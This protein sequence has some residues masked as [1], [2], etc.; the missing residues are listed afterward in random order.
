MTE[1]TA[2]VALTVLALYREPDAL[3]SESIAA[4]GSAG[5]HVTRASSDRDFLHRLL[6]VRYQIIVLD[7]DAVDM[8][9]ATLVRQVL[10]IQGDHST[11]VT[12][13][14]ERPWLETNVLLALEA[15]EVL[16]RPF[17]SSQLVAVAFQL[18]QRLR[19]RTPSPPEDYRTY[20]THLCQLLQIMSDTMAADTYPDALRAL[21]VNLRQIFQHR[22]VGI[23]HATP[24]D[25]IIYV[26]TPETAADTPLGRRLAVALLKRYE[27]LCGLQVN[28]ATLQERI[29]ADA[30]A[31]AAGS[32]PVTET[33]L[34]LPFLGGGEVRGVLGLSNLT[35]SDYRDGNLPFVYLLASRLYPVLT[36]L[37]QLKNLAFRDG[38]TGLHN[39]AH[40]EEAVTKALQHSRRSGRGFCVVLL[41][42]DHLKR[43][44]DQL[45][46]RAGDL[47][48]RDFAHLL[49]SVSR[50]TDTVG[51]LGGDEFLV[52]LPDT[53][54]PGLQAFLLR[55]FALITTHRTLWAGQP[56]PISASAG[57]TLVEAGEALVLTASDVIGRSDAAMY[58]A[59]RGGKSC[60]AIW[61]PESASGG[62]AVGLS[63]PLPPMPG[64]N[65]GRP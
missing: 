31:T 55:L 14:H 62:G 9:V 39:R 38:L 35:E 22:A 12:T 61:S 37:N 48:L 41:D 1:P 42:L 47:L 2:P 18:V 4:L 15:P 46:H 65:G 26:S 52:L 59:K 63:T 56:Y 11:I 16:L 13:T 33:D 27:S 20:R 6:E 5:F 21:A 57:A 50:T 34:L 64:Q 53:P 58:T 7:T 44:N 23:F 25:S 32:L 45:G 30:E 28:R 60:W 29:E 36:A 10:R 19:V 49:L 51:R 8:D 3:L 43:T 24:T 17:A 54:A 40:V